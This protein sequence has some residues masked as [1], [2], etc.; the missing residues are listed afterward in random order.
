MPDESLLEG[1]D[2]FRLLDRESE[3]V[4]AHFRSGP[5]WQRPSRCEGWSTRDMLGHLMGLEDYVRAN[6]DKR[7]RALVDEGRSAGGHGIG[8]FNQWQI[9]QY[10]DVPTDELVERWHEANLTGRARLRERGRDGV[11]DTSIG[12][13]SS[14]LQT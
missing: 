6:L 13:Y 9:E 3:R 2:P 10:A 14:W 4:Y 12:D 8:G 11:V 7:V 1:L 5:D